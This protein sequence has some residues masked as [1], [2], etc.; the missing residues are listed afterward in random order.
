MNLNG[1]KT[2]VLKSLVYFFTKTLERGRIIYVFFL[3][4]IKR[5]SDM[6]NCLTIKYK[7]AAH[8]SH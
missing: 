4:T 1:R 7:V 8:I 3:P 5:K 6:S 2:A